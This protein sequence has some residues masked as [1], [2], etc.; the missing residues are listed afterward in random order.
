MKSNIIKQRC[1]Q[2]PRAKLDLFLVALWVNFTDSQILCEAQWVF[3]TKET[4]DYDVVVSIHDRILVGVYS[5]T[6]SE[7]TEAEIEKFVGNL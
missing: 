3:Q 7:R 1:F 2:I 6:Y 4:G 5:Q